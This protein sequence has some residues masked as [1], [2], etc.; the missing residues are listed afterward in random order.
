MYAKECL[1][2]ICKK[3]EDFELTPGLSQPVL[4]KEKNHAATFS[5]DLHLLLRHE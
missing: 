1:Y 5:V 4:L 3:R 2:F